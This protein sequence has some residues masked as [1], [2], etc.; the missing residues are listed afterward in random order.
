MSGQARNELMIS[1]TFTHNILLYF[2]ISRGQKWKMTVSYYKRRPLLAA[3]TLHCV[4]VQ[5]SACNGYRYAVDYMHVIVI[6]SYISSY[7]LYLTLW[8]SLFQR[9]NIYM[10]RL[11]T[12]TMRMWVNLHFISCFFVC[13]GCIFQLLY[14]KQ[15]M[16]II[17]VSE[18][19]VL[20]TPHTYVSVH[21]CSNFT[22]V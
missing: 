6:H 14:I 3:C 13:H 20:R 16:K 2:V 18:V 4:F 8:S 7:L 22:A 10:C 21:H 11:Y 12:G 9:H 19:H 1:L 15:M 17:H 5:H